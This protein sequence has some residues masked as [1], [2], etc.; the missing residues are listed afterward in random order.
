MSQQPELTLTP[1][2]RRSHPETSRLAARSIDGLSDKRQAVLSIVATYG[3]LTHEG[4]IRRYNE[5]RIEFD[6][7]IPKQTDSGIRSRCAELV[8]MGLVEAVDGD[9]GVTASGRKCNVWRVKP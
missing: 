3:P 6:M 4:I 2:T 5:K 7:I 8:R 9:H 1:G